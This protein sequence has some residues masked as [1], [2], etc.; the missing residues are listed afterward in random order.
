M[1]L[2][3]TKSLRLQIETESRFLRHYSQSITVSRL[4]DGSAAIS[5]PDLKREWPMM[6]QEE[7]KEFAQALYQWAIAEVIP[8]ELNDRQDLTGLL[9]FVMK[10]GDWSHRNGLA[11]AGAKSVAPQEAIEILSGRLRDSGSAIIGALSE[12]RHEGAVAALREH[13][14]FLWIQRDIL[15]PTEEPKYNQTATH[16]ICCISGLLRMGESPAE[17]EPKVRLLSKHPN[18]S[19]RHYCAQALYRHYDWLKKPPPLKDYG[20]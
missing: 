9:R 16:A 3:A 19:E 2:K 17:F 8:I 18:K 7:R 15:D 6:S 14:E 1:D 11:K 20:A 12:I 5:L 10:A 13:L 4:W